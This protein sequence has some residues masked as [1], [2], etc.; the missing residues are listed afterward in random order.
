MKKRVWISALG[1][2]LG[3]SVAAKMLGTP[4]DATKFTPSTSQQ[5]FD[6]TQ[7]VNFDDY[8]VQTRAR[9]QADKVYMDERNKAIELAAATPYEI[10]PAATCTAD[11]TKGILL[12]HGLSDMPFAMQ[13][14]ANSFAERCF[15]VRSILLPGHGTRAADL[16]SV[17]RKD[18]LEAARFG[19]STLKKEVDEVYIGGF[20]LGGLISAYLTAED[21]EIK[22][23]FLVSPSLKIKRNLAISQSVWVRHIVAWADTDPQDDYARYESMP[24]HGLAET[25]QLTQDLKSLLKHKPIQQ[26]VLLVQSDD[27]SIIDT[28]QNKQ[29][30]T[31]FMQSTYSK[32][33]IYKQDS[34][35]SVDQGDDRIQYQNSYLPQDKVLNF[36]HQ[37]IHITPNNAHYG[38]SGAYRNCGINSDDRNQQVVDAC[39]NTAKPWRGET[40]GT[41]R[42]T[43]SG[44]PLMRLTYN[45][46][47]EAM[48]KQVDQF[49]SSY[50]SR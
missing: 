25:Y 44:E 46:L 36:S 33:L 47:Y 3:S 38:E 41:D 40:V 22:G 30:F 28:Q 34:Q 19:V 21:A 5:T 2:V 14:M 43:A 7:Y 18:W 15:L 8:R 39:L 35:L 4:P 31:Q 9:L 13:D 37:A 17:T 12:I 29:Y 10:K 42:V 20:S 48:F 27:D 6:A 23:L 24:M 49:L 1:L 16:M 50:P 26:P 32:A 11:K 45:P